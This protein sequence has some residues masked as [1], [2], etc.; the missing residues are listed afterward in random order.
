MTTSENQQF[1]YAKNKDTDQLCSN[2]AVTAQLISAFVFATPIVP[3]QSFKLVAFFC[4]ST[5]RSVSDLVGNPNC[6]FSHKMAQFSYRHTWYMYIK[7]FCL[8]N[9]KPCHSLHIN[10][11]MFSMA[12]CQCFRRQYFH[13]LYSL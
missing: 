1:A 5:D 2:C 4:D 10:F 6:W 7:K 11:V 13:H 9:K 3:F 8:D 12:H